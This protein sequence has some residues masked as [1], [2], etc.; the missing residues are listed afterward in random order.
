[1]SSSYLDGLRITKESDLICDPRFLIL[2]DLSGNPIRKEYYR[3]AGR[4][5]DFS[6]DLARYVRSEV[7]KAFLQPDPRFYDPPPREVNLDGEIKKLICNLHGYFQSSSRP[8]LKFNYLLDGLLDPDFKTTLKKIRF[9]SLV[10]HGFYG[11]FCERDPDLDSYPS[12]LIDD[13]GQIYNYRYWFFWSEED[14]GDEKWAWEPIQPLSEDCRAEYTDTLLSMLPESIEE[15][16]EREVLLSITSSSAD[17]NIPGRGSLPHYIEKSMDQF[18]YCSNEPL[19]AKLVY[20]QKC[21]GDTR[22]ASVLSIQHSNT[23]K[24][25]EKQCS[26]IAEDLPHSVYT[27]DKDKFEKNYS[28]LKKDFDRFLCRDMRKDGLT[29]NR[30]LM[31]LTLEILAK[32]YPHIGLFKRF[33]RVFSEWHYYYPEEPDKWYSPPRGVGL[34]MSSAL[35]TI[36]GC[37]LIQ[38]TIDR[39]RMDGGLYLGNCRGLVYHD[40]TALGFEDETDLE[41][42]DEMEDLVFE[43]YQLLK[44][45]K[46]SFYGDGFVLC[47]VYTGS[48]DNKYSY[49]EAFLN[50]PFYACN[51]VHAKDMVQS[52]VRYKTNLNILDYIPLYERYWGTELYKLETRKPYRLGGW[53]PSVFLGVDTSFLFYEDTPEEKASLH[54]CSAHML[55][56]PISKKGLNNK[57]KFRTPLEAWLGP[58]L[59]LGKYQADYNYNLTM[60]DAY[61]KFSNFNQGGSLCKAY[62]L[63]AKKRLELFNK[64]LTI[65]NTMTATKVF[66]FWTRQFPYIDFLPQYEWFKHQDIEERRSDHQMYDL[67]PYKNKYLGFIKALNPKN[68]KL[69]NVVPYPLPPSIDVRSKSLT[70]EERKLT[71][72][73][74]AGIGGTYSTLPTYIHYMDNYYDCSDLPYIHP[75]NVVRA[76]AAHYFFPQIPLIP[77]LIEEKESVKNYRLSHFNTWMNESPFANLYKHLV[78]RLGWSVMGKI[79]LMR[80]EVY[81]DYIFQA[82][83]EQKVFRVSSPQPCNVPLPPPDDIENNFFLGDLY[84]EVLRFTE[85][86]FS[87]I[88]ALEALSPVLTSSELNEDENRE[89]WE[90]FRETHNEYDSDEYEGSNEILFLGNSHRFSPDGQSLLSGSSGE[91]S[92]SC[93]DPFEGFAATQDEESAESNNSGDQGRD[94]RSDLSVMSDQ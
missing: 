46:K 7:Q 20:V 51:I 39:C 87:N 12:Y 35:T 25:I 38:V 80:D 59:I 6:I 13:I 32:K 60:G 70:S 92:I 85:M 14:P 57:T 93:E 50:S 48:L 63:L 69:D 72:K 40:D 37:A 53:I 5:I 86:R 11:R 73:M 67:F 16:D 27:S 22:R 66:E 4:P 61:R 65:D 83:N 68:I 84:L 17:S 10:R 36:M 42:Y 43:D 33:K 88:A 1:M 26:V 45:K 49:Q 82:L 56:K 89:F 76:C 58:N 75:E 74:P 30:E 52:I 81:T 78:K 19:R 9:K 47:E 34:G 23:I 24:L 71:L 54:A 90:G 15:I 44:N 21:P 8:V 77:Y 18:N 29:K 64:F 2:P 55:E 94:E 79:E 41:T 62:F 91:S 31:V 28:Q 3:E